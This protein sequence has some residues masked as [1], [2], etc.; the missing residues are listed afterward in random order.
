MEPEDS[1]P[2]SQEPGTGPCPDPE[3]SSSRPHFLTSKLVRIPAE[4]H[5]KKKLPACLSV[6]M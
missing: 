5:I 4:A 1:L 2:C 6:R 3:E